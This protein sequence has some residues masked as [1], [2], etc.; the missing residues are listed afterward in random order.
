MGFIRHTAWLRSEISVGYIFCFK[1]ESS[2]A[3]PRE[4]PPSSYAACVLAPA[5]T[6]SGQVSG[7]ANRRGPVG[8]ADAGAG[9]RLVIGPIGSHPDFNAVIVSET[10]QLWC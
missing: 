10:P 7:G 3:P 2:G 5:C 8:Q 1:N 4:M 6:Q 9:D